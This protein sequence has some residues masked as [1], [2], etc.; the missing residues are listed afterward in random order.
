MRITDP[1]DVFLALTSYPPGDSAGEAELAL[2]RARIEDAFAAGGGVLET[3]KQAG[4]F[5]SRKT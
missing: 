2:F 5:T 3:S 1:E 4:L